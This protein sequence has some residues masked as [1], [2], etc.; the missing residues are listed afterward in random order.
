MI[1][2]MFIS[3]VFSSR[4]RHTRCALV[5]VGQTLCSSD[6]MPAFWSRQSPYRAPLVLDSPEKIAR[7]YETRRA[8]GLE[9]GMLVANPAPED[10]EI[11]EIGRASRRERVCPYV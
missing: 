9:G 1:V 10:D 8:L 2:S 11:P 6:L 4:R 7:L 3:F 5:T